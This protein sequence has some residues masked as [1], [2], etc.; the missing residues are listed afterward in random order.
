MAIDM[1]LFNMMIIYL[2]IVGVTFIILKVFNRS[3]ISGLSKYVFMAVVVIIIETPTYNDISF[4]K[5]VL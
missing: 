4:W 2:A 5:L 3:V 1:I